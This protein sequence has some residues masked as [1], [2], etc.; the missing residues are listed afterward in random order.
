MRNKWVYLLSLSHYQCVCFL[1]VCVRWGVIQGLWPQGIR[2][3]SIIKTRAGR[4]EGGSGWGVFGTRSVYWSGRLSCHTRSKDSPLIWG[5]CRRQHTLT[6]VTLFTYT[7]TQTWRVL[8]VCKHCQKAGKLSASQKKS[9]ADKNRSE[10]RL[11][12]V[13]R[14]QL[15]AACYVFSFSHICRGFSTLSTSVSWP[16]GLVSMV[17]WYTVWMDFS[18]GLN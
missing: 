4:A 6:H 10:E 12:G 9:P 17:L 3:P 18:T 15:T 8:L 2:R 13:K 5:V 7:H 14:P 16:R 11:S 1:Y